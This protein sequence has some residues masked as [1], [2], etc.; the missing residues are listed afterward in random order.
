MVCPMCGGRLRKGRRE[1]FYGGISLGEHEAEVCERCGEVFF[2]EEAS[3]AIDLLAKERGVWGLEA[4]TKVSYSGNS[5]IVRIP[6][7]IAEYMGIKRGDGVR[8]HPE[9]KQRIV[10]E[11][12]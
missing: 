9:G 6:K 4:R 12:I 11:L 5:L 2:T 10:V 1:Y 8:I 3:D 7:E